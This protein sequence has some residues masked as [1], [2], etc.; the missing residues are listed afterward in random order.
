[1][2][3]PIINEAANRKDWASR[4]DRLVLQLNGVLPSLET[5]AN[6]TFGGDVSGSVYLTGQGNPQAN[7]TLDTVNSNVGNFTN[8]S[9]TVNA[10]GLVTA[11]SSGIGIA[12]AEFTYSV[13]SGTGP[14]TPLTTAQWNRRGL[15]TSVS[16]TITGASLS[17][18]IVTLPA[19]TYLANIEAAVSTLVATV[20]AVSRLQ[21]TTGNITYCE[22]PNAVIP[23]GQQTAVTVGHGI[24][25]IAGAHN[26]EIDTYAVVAGGA[27]TGGAAQS[28][29]SPEIYVRATFLKVA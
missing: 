17:G 21:D 9:I 10:K 26:F 2:V 24:V 25:T 29:G 20:T 23:S 7:L 18:N 19:G 15:N 6:L 12:A 13:A 22:T 5:N 14:D 8:A 3:M 16:N 4:M 11:A 28:N 1:M 27:A